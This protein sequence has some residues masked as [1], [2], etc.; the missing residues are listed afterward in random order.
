MDKW[1]KISSKIYV[2]DYLVILYFVSITFSEK[3]QKINDYFLG[4]PDGKLS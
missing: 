4:L 1:K 3:A 2:M